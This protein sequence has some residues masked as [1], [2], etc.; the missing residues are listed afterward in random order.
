MNKNFDEITKEEL[1]TL[2][3]KDNMIKAE[4]AHMFDVI[5]T[6]LKISY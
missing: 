5:K 1:E 6:M 4:I 2:Y 3:I